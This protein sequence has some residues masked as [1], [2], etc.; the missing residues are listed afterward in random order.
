MRDL[1]TSV[2]AV[3]VL[4]SEMDPSQPEDPAAIAMFEEAAQAM[5]YAA[6]A[7][8]GFRQLLEAALHGVRPIPIIGAAGALP[9]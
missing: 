7:R 9:E 5:H 4:A 6:A 1:I 3:A 2:D 8:P